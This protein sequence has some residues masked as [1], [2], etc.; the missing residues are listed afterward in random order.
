MT[1][2]TNM[3]SIAKQASKQ[4][5]KSYF[6]QILM[7]GKLRSI[8]LMNLTGNLSLILTRVQTKTTTNVP[9]TTQKNRMDFQRIGNVT[10]YSVIRLIQKLRSGLKNVIERA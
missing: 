2:N 7:S 10:E 1:K 6:R 3:D 5:S 4:A 8:S 9:Y